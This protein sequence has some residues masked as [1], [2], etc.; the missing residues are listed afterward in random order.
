ME[1]TLRE[2]VAHLWDDVMAIDY[3][4]AEVSAEFGGE[5]PMK[6]VMRGQLEKARATL[7]LLHEAFSSKDAIE[8]REPSER[9]VELTRTYFQKGF[10]PRS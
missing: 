10:S 9:A 2:F 8:F 1:A 5:D 3:L 6:P 7:E 4:L